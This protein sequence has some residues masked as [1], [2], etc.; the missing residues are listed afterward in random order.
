[1]MATTVGQQ[2]L[3]AARAAFADGDVRSL[4]VLP[5][6]LQQ[7]WLRSR[8]AGLQPGQEPD[9]RPLLGD[10]RHLSHP[11]DRRLARCVQ[12]ELEQ[13]WAAFGGRGWTMFCANRDG[14]V[15]AQQAH[16]L[17]DAPLL[18]P[19]QVGRQLGETEI[20][21]T[22]PAVSLADDV[23]AL[24]R[25]NEHYL[26]R[27][28]PVFCLSEPLHDLDGRVCGVIDITGLGERD[29]ALLQG[30]FRQAALASENR[31]F[32]SLT[33]VHLLAVQHDPRWL[34]SPLQGLL[35]VQE[36]G[37]LRAANRVARRLLG[38]PRRGPL[39]LLGLEA[40]FAGASAAQRRRL[41]QPGAAHRVR[42]G[43]GSAVYLQRLQ[44]PRGAAHRSTVRS[45]PA[46]PGAPLLRDQQREAA[47]RAA[48]AADGNLSLAARQLGISRT[49]LYKL[50][51]D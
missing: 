3:V 32:H 12:P 27:F 29:P 25:G 26:Q 30:Y 10:G 51:R 42:L 1:M 41:L 44:G 43:E 40:L 47:R 2:Q 14:M 50:L 35:A 9:Y 15:I 28:A 49:T 11:D 31:L 22:A 19:I 33:D 46:D 24:V 23:P 20:G 39:P 34:A 17:E 37:Q 6:P 5:L 38:L 36:D 16:G 48:Q 18:R 21:T 13:L 7:S 45:T 8:A 4:G